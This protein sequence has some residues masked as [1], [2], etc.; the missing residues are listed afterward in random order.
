LAVQAIGSAIYGNVRTDPQI[1]AQLARQGSAD[2]AVV[3]DFTPEQ[4]Q[5]TFLQGLGNII[6]QSGDTIY[7]T[8]VTTSGVRDIAGEYWVGAVLPWNGR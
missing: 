4:F 2:V 6:K 5:L 7:M 3:F 8:G 1:S